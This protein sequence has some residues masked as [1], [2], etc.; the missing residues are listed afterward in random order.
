MAHSEIGQNVGE[1]QIVGTGAAHGGTATALT[2]ARA[3]AVRDIVWRAL[4]PCH[5]D[6]L[7]IIVDREHAPASTSRRQSP[8]CPNRSPGPGRGQAAAPRQLIQR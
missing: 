5:R 7:R 6:R 2:P 8:E 4:S 3:N 1:D